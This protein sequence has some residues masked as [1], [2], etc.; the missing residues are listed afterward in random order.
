M[1][2]LL[3]DLKYAVR[4]LVKAPAFALF[5]VG[6]LALGIAANTSIFSF[7]NT[8]LL[9]PLPYR[10]PGRLVMVWEDASYIG[11]P[12]NTP[13][14]GN[15]YD[16][17]EQNRVFDDMAATRDASFSLTGGTV[18]EEILGRQVSWNLFQVLGVYPFLGRDFL[19]EEDNANTGDVA[20]LSHALWR[21]SFG[22][23]P[24]IVGK[25]I[26]LDN[27]EYTVVGVMP[28][29]FEFPD[30]ASAIWVP[31]GFS[32][33]QATN[34]H[35]H[36]LQ[37]VARLKPGVTLAQANANLAAVSKN[38]AEKNPDS[39]THI[40][41]YAVPLRQDRVG[42][43]RLAI[44]ILLGAV[45]FVL[46][47]ACANVANLLLARA[48]GRQ[49][50]L[51]VRMALG[52]GRQRI[53]RQLLTESLLLAGLA[54]LFG[55]ML[56]FW[57]AAL[58]SRLIP[59][60]VPLPP[61]SGIDARVFVFSVFVSMATGVLF[62]IMPALRLSSVNLSDALKWAGGRSRSV[63][64][65]KYTRNLLVVVEVALAVILLSGAGLM[66]QTFANLRLLNPGFDTDRVLTLHVP[67]PVPK[68][69]ELSKRT[70]FYDQVLERVNRLPGVLAAGFTTWVPLTNRGG[71][72]GFTI[73]GQPPPAPGE[74]KDAN[75]RV[76]SKDYI[77]TMSMPLK[78][79]R[80]FSGDE[81]RNSTL[82]LLVNQAMARQFW[83]GGNPLGQRMKLGG[84]ASEDPWFTVI[85]IVGDVHQM[86]LNV[87]PRA[88]MYV[89][90]SQYEYFAPGY[91][92]VKTTGDPLRFAS[93]I[94]DQIWAVDKDQ[95]V[96]DV[97][98]MQA[99]VDEE[100]SPRRL[101]ATILGAFSGLALL[102]AS[103]GIYAVLSYGVA[104]R[105]QEIGLR[106]AL[107]A[108]PGNVLRMVIGQ[109]FALTLTGV[110]IGL[111]GA[112]ALTRVLTN[113]LYDVSASDPATLVATA[114]LFCCVALLACYIPARRAMRVDPMVALRYE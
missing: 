29:G 65:G 13:A 88:E 37:V 73:D 74:F 44:Y 41:A 23:D 64:H 84:Y 104:Q 106:I 38:L 16:W 1:A 61:D 59:A 72:T 111:G 56:S 94:R 79:G 113:L 7:A 4:M 89:P 102:L 3:H 57:G 85:G 80:L 92:A 31:L 91:L 109:G 55:I 68:Y 99:I 76:I 43:L 42:N 97:M 45:G 47:I 52:A 26:E 101:Q 33:E 20:I 90:Y 87:A 58:L 112:L 35:Q 12:T 6:V 82:V 2:T 75:L 9:R 32:P 21:Q 98:P 11:F 14:P 40:G 50:E 30:R 36:F 105:T 8:V 46:L 110:A 103:L 60:G 27:Q 28:Q 69:L 100:L 78:S 51:A 34:H 25:K 53:L 114:A 96:A 22:G 62:G 49:R 67:L 39:N 86:G 24:K 17:K 54:G 93:A 63:A 5:S 71:S 48:A 10:D 83:H 70:A 95:P 108:Q 18:P 77:R 107:G 19:A 66:I 15:F 81:R